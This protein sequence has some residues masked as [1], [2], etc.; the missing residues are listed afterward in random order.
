[1]KKKIIFSL[2]GLA[3]GGCAEVTQNGMF[4]GIDAEIRTHGIQQTQ[5]IKTPQDAENVKK[6]VNT[7]L[8]SPLTQENAVRITLINNRQLQQTYGQIGI[9]Q[10]ELVQAGLMS[11]PLFG[12]KFGHRGGTT[13][14]TIGIEAA[15]MDLL[16]MPLRRE[17]KSV[18]LEETQWRVGDEILKKT[19]DAKLAYI[20]ARIAEEKIKLYKPIL[21]SHEV[22]VQLA[23]RQN[24]AGNLSKRDFLK[25]QDAYERARLKSLD[26]NKENSEAREAL[27]RVLGLYGS[28]TMY[29]LSQKPLRLK[30]PQFQKT[31]LESKAIAN[32]LDIRASIKAVD[33]AALDAGYMQKTRLVSE[34]SILAEQERVTHE[35]ALNSFGIAIPIPIFDFG[36]GRA[37]EA[38]VRYNQSVHR[39]YEMAI[40]IRSEVREKYAN[41][42]YMHDKALRY[43]T[44]IVKTNEEILQETQ[45]YYNGMLDGVYELLEDHRRL[46]EARMEAL[47]ALGEA[48]RSQMEFEYVMGGKI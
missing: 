20:D 12:Y 5:W 21:K 18:A 29:A 48:K 9:S 1:M 15:F 30:Y 45:L 44:V 31:K 32:R 35:S 13:E 7:L 38:Q 28:Q 24:T 26:L 11:N 27:N 37:N 17:L 10:S 47:D 43:N 16:W 33:F 39:L 22:S 6:S 34:V 23:I 42:R 41:L 4:H 25:I 3:F 2:I 46:A 8:S 40:N 36:Q 19:R 14:A